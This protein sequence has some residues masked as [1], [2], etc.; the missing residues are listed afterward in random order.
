MDHGVAR[1]NECVPQT[2]ISVHKNKIKDNSSQSI[3]NTEIMDGLP[4]VFLSVDANL[5]SLDCPA[6]AMRLEDVMKAKS[7]QVLLWHCQLCYMNNKKHA[8]HINFF[9]LKM[10]VCSA[11]VT[12]PGRVWGW[13][14][15]GWPAR[16]W[17]SLLRQQLHTSNEVQRN[18][19]NHPK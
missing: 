8:L 1:W 13:T 5:L 18:Q 15:S 7:P 4:E 17:G 9:C 2:N 11:V 3:R 14:T 19:N 6:V 10:H 16:D 12:S